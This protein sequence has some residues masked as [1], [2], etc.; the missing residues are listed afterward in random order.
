VSEEKPMAVVAELPR[1]SARSVHHQPPIEGRMSMGAGT[2]APAQPAKRDVK[3]ATAAPIPSS[4]QAA[5][6]HRER[7]AGRHGNRGG[8]AVLKSRAYL[9]PM[10]P[11]RYAYRPL[12]RPR[13]IAALFGLF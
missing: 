5:Q 1:R 9:R 7:R 11:M 12:R 3:L 4:P 8:I 10:R 13:G 6:P 2:I